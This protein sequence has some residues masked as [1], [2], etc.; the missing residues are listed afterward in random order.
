MTLAAPLLAA[1]RARGLSVGTAESLT[2]GL[3]VAALTDVPGASASVVGSVVSYATRV[4]RDVLG[5]PGPLLEERG[6]V[7]AEVARQM[8]LGVCRVLGC[9][10]GLATTGVAGP[11]PQDGQE[12]GTVF[13]AVAVPGTGGTAATGAE[14]VERLALSGSRDEIRRL[15]VEAVLALALAVVDSQPPL[16][17]AEEVVS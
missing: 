2:G 12:V 13:V 3:V 11:D 1:L 5:V 16:A 15:A 8:A 4:K 9:D 14:R 10:V 6:A 7:D 17:G